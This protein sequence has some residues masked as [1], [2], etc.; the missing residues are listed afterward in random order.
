M[1]KRKGPQRSSNPHVPRPDIVAGN[2]NAAGNGNGN[3]KRRRKAKP[4][5]TKANETA[6]AIAP[7]VPKKGV[8]KKPL[9]PSNDTDRKSRHKPWKPT[10]QQLEMHRL[11]CEGTR[12]LKE[13][14]DVYGI[15]IQAIRASNLKVNRYLAQLRISEIRSLKSDHETRLMY[16]YREAILAWHRSKNDIETTSETVDKNGKSVTSSSRGTPG[17]VQFLAEA[18]ACLL[19][20]EKI[21]GAHEPLEVR[22]SGEVRVAGMSREDAIRSRIDQLAGMLKP[23]E[24]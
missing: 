4:K 3:G 10:A 23:G 21:W 2:G 13:I 11:W 24:N 7:I 8:H 22:H 15:T 20:I 14:G 19:Q 18:R 9:V 5:K 12:T 6:D 1:A 16:Q 17:N